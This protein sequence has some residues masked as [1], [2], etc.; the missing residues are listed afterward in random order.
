MVPD[1]TREMYT[2]ERDGDDCDDDDNEM[3]EE[4]EKDDYSDDHFPAV[5]TIIM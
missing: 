5:I 1:A 4:G 2:L 3:D